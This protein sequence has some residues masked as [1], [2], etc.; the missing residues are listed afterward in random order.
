M[1]VIREPAGLTIEAKEMI[2]VGPISLAQVVDVL[3]ESLLVQVGD[4]TRELLLRY[5]ML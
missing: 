2:S 4:A 5:S 1:R 3:E